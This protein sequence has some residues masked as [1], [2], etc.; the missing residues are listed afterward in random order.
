M[1]DKTA[2]EECPVCALWKTKV[3]FLMLPCGHDDICRSCIIQ[4]Y[5]SRNRKCPVCRKLITHSFIQPYLV[6]AATTTNQTISVQNHV[7]TTIQ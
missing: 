4:T 7:C 6:T 2:V 3:E 1:D 5:R